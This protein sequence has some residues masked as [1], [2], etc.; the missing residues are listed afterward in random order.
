MAMDP[1]NDE[2]VKRLT[3]QIQYEK[4]P[5]KVLQLTRE[6]CRILDGGKPPESGDSAM[7]F[8]R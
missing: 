7:D 5:D 8:V 3:A 2:R 6:L 4:D 1:A